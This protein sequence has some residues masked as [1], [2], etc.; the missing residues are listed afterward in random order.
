MAQAG[1]GDLVATYWL[2]LLAPART[3]PALVERI[4][5]EVVD[6]LQSS[7]MKSALLEKGAE[8]GGGGSEEFGVFIRSETA[9]FKKVIE[10]AGL[11][12]E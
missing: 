5:R 6:V 2:G 12:A 3:A 10:A 9:R 1:A 11:R 8:P 7:G 4:N